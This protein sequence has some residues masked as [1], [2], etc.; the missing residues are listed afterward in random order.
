MSDRS[1]SRFAVLLAV[2]ALIAC[3]GVAAFF[4]LRRGGNGPR[5]AE[6][7]DTLPRPGSET[8]REMVSAF[9]AGVAA[10]DV[11]ATERAKTA[12]TRATELVP[13]EP[14]AW[15]DL[16]LLRIRLR[17]YDAAAKDLEQAHKLAPESG[18]IERLLGLLA[19]LTAQDGQYA[20]AIA[21]LRRAVELAPGDLKA[22]FAL[23]KEVERQADPDSE[24]EALRMSGELL[25]LQPDNLY[26]LLERARLA[27]KRGDAQALGDSIARLGRLG[28]SWPTKVQ[29]A[30]RE[31]EK[32]ANANPRSAVTRVVLMRNLLVQTPAFRRGM[33]AVE[34]TGGTV[35]EPI[36]TFLRLAP[37]PPT[38]SPPDDALAFAVEPQG[39]AGASRWDTLLAV[40]MTG[41]GPSVLYV[42]DGRAVRQVD[43]AGAVLPFP[44]GPQAVPPSSAGVLSVDWNSDYRMDL[45]FAGAGG[46]KVFEQKEDGTFAD[47]TAA[48]KL[49]PAILSADAFGVWAADIEMDGDLDLVLGARQGRAS[50]LRNNG[51]GTFT[52]VPAI[53]GATDLRDFAWTDLD[54]DGDPDAALLDARGGLRI[55]TNERAG[56]FQLRPGPEGLGT[57]AALAV[58]DVNSDGV[59]DLLAMRADGTVLRISDRDDGHA[60]DMVEVVRLPGTV[61]NAPRILVADLDNNGA[62]DLI[63]WG[64]SGGWIAVADQ[65]GGFRTLTAPAGLS[66]FAVADLNSDG[67]LDL[68]GLSQ[69]GRPARGL[70]RGTK[71]Y[72]WQVIRPRGA[73]TFGDGRINSFGLGGEVEVRA[74]LLVQKQVI[75][76]PILHFGL[77]DRAES[78]VARIVWPNG[79]VQAEFDARA[80]QDGVTEQRLKGSCPFLFAFDG[81][82]VRFITDFIWRS[83]LGLRINAQDTAGAGQTEDWV[84]IRGDQLAPRDGSYD[85]RIT[86]ELWETHYWDHVALMVVDHPSGTEVFV[87][88]RFARRPP[89]LAVQATGPLHPVAYARDDRGRDVTEEVSARDGRYLDHFDRGFYQGVARDHWV[90][91]ELG[92]DVPRDRPIRLVA[93]GWIHPTDSS[94]NVAIGQGGKI[95]PQ[96]L[97]LEVQASGGDWTVARPDLG[98]PAGKHKTIVVDLDGVFTPGGPRRFRLRTNLEVFWDSLAVAVAAPETTLKTQ[99]LA[100][101]SAE[102]RHRGYS[103]MTQA[104][105]SSPELPHYDTLAGTGQRWRDLIGFYTRFGDVREL[106]KAVDDRYVIANAGDELAL[107][108]PAPPPPPEG[109]VRD[110]VLIGDGWNKDGD[111]NTA[112]SQTVLP[113]PSHARPGYDSPPG[114]LEDDPVYRFHPEDWREYHTRYI[115]PGDFQNGLRPRWDSPPRPE[116]E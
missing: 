3:V 75:T 63:G 35:G 74:G 79:T 11:D 105:A 57:L 76:G 18:A 38:P 71:D 52:D 14:A 41:K 10:L 16:G 66:V 39:E 12:L 56:R 28:S 40:S 48:T 95:K 107:R 7:K 1:R 70:G 60:W 111:F 47:V 26:V 64:S 4:V 23:V 54:G 19:S 32:A 96:G 109:W 8:Y 34:V 103:L 84:K 98:F 80:D 92:D 68:A 5:V 99:R 2:A 101:Q 106:L 61:G 42:A 91:V 6:A 59:M 87:D 116:S 89:P 85:I 58:A 22:R 67:R 94:I 115:T 108:F 90:E 43:G 53:E 86:A 81:T 49:D 78:D 65:K 37:P 112:F 73:R 31:L 104:D 88:E 36:E 20:E 24:A 82:S 46:L 30:Y 114:A 113:L 51:D 44:G 77:G 72:H 17:D 100:P 45:V 97:V 21:H 62:A 83:P 69:D 50:V 110:F 13:A 102:L 25:K 93:H 9:Y 33:A 27:V 55:Y 29:E 15:A